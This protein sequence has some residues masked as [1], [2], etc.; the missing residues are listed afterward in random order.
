MAGRLVVVSNRVMV[1]TGRQSGSAGGLAVGVQA[2][3]RDKGGIW[4]GWSG[5]TIAEAAERKISTVDKDGVSYVLCDL[6]KAEHGEYY[7]GMANRTLWPL[8]HYRIDLTSFQHEWYRT[9]R[10]VNEL[11]AEALAGRVTPE[12][13]IW[14]QDFHLIPMSTEL[15]RRGVTGPIGFFLHVP[16]P[17]VQLFLTLPWHRELVEDL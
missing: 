2:A 1:P 7:G 3:L 11:F 14:V 5:E 16:F 13:R 10:K 12:D 4:F 17:P 6:T 9:Y 8:L 15:R